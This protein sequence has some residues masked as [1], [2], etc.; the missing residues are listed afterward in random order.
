MKF[1]E[2]RRKAKLYQQW[3][4]RAGLPSEAVPH[5]ADKVETP[6]RGPT[7]EVVTPEADQPQGL[8]V[9][10]DSGV[11]THPEVTGNMMAEID[12]R[13]RRL[14]ILYI[15]LGAALI[16]LCASLILLIIHSC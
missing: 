7:S 9:K 5:E 14:P 1:F 11:V 8:Y 12:K 13:Q 16:I 10:P 4:K 15:L 2:K 6:L 3:V